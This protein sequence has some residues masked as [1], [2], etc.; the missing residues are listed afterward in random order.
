MSMQRLR[1]PAFTTAGST[2]AVW[3]G[4][5]AFDVDANDDAAVIATTKVAFRFFILVNDECFVGWLL[6][7]H[8]NARSHTQ[9]LQ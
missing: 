2:T 4:R 8:E 7:R 1:R 6:L 9:Y 3:T 5:K